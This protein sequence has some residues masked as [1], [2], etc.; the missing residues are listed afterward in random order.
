MAKNHGPQIHHWR[1]SLLFSSLIFLLFSCSS[2]VDTTEWVSTLKSDLA[3]LEIAATE[4]T[5]EQFEQFVKATDYITEAEKDNY[6]GSVYKKDEWTIDPNANW[7]HPMGKSSSIDEIMDHPVVQVTYNDAMAYCNWAKV[8]LPSEEE[9]RHAC[10][11]GK[12]SQKNINISHGQT[13]DDVDGYLYT[14]PAKK[15]PPNALNLYGMFGNV[16]EITASKFD[17]ESSIYAMKGGSFLCDEEYCKGYSA[18]SR[19]SI[20]KNDAYFH[21]GFRVVKD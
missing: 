9:W 6:G 8:R 13:K 21:V 18:D 16:W 10:L 4:V 14:S 7:R 5:N 15:F 12:T 2:E 1:K 11:E 20:S 19:Q 3:P 17:S